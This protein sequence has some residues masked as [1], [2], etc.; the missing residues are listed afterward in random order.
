MALG[1]RA[2]GNDHLMVFIIFVPQTP[3]AML[4]SVWPHHPD[5][6]LWI[7]EKPVIQERVRP[8]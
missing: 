2:R 7:K 3:A 1:S 8:I 5:Q 6:P 4:F